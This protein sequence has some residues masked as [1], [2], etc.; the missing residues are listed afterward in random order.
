MTRCKAL[1]CALL[2]LASVLAPAARA[3][4]PVTVTEPPAG[5]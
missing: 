5:R 2:L 3:E 1:L 4:W